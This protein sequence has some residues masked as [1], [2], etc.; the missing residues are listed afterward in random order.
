MCKDED[1][2]QKCFPLQVHVNIVNLKTSF[3]YPKYLGDN[4]QA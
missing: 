3:G 4:M 2:G 1:K